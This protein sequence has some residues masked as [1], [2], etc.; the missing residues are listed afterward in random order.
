M[1]GAVCT[2]VLRN[3]YYFPNIK[4]D[5]RNAPKRLR[6]TV[7]MY[8]IIFNV[9]LY[10]N[11]YNGVDKTF[12]Y[13]LTKMALLC[14]VSVQ[15]APL[16]LC[17]YLLFYLLLI[18][19]FTH[20]T[21]AL[22][23]YDRGTLLDIG[24]RFTNLVQDTLSPNPV[25]S[26]PLEI[27][28]NVENKGHRR[29]NKKHCGN[30]AGIRNRL[31]KRAH[32]PPLPSILLA[33]VQS[34]ENKMDDLRARISFQRDIRDCNIICLTETWLTP[35]V[36]DTDVTPSDNFSVLRMDRTAEAGKSKGVIHD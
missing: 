1:C 35:S 12:I 17:F 34:L 20:I 2:I 18:S 19:L 7:I 30:S 11:F 31:R 3:A 36:P 14:S 10:V 29:R 15:V 25:P 16:R 26:W 28:R 13:S 24:N 9:F 23:T 22:I 4:D 33:N 8:L 21:S 6:K 27:L 32:S 5:S